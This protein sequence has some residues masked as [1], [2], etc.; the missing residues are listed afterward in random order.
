MSQKAESTHCEELV[1]ILIAAGN[2][3]RLGQPK[4]IVKKDNESLLSRSAKLG[5][6]SCNSVLCVLGFQAEE[7]KNDIQSL[8]V[9]C[10]V[11]KQWQIGMGSSIACAIK[12]LPPQTQAVMIMLCDQWALNEN[13]I[14]ALVETW[15]KNKS[16]IVTSEYIDF[17]TDQNVLGATAIFP[18]AYFPLLAEL[19]EKGARKILENNR[20]NLITVN[21][22]S[23]AFDLDTPQDLEKFLTETQGIE[24]QSSKNNFNKST[25]NSY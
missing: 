23:A 25:I 22:S 18:R 12:Q 6:N 2:S 16:Q 10:I 19:K 4:Q 24:K 1:C 14:E 3:S 13:D 11:N 15:R 20:A 5:L 21:L 7:F 8:S 17:E 9:E